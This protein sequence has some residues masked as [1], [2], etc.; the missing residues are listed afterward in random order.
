[1]RKIAAFLFMSL[2]TFFSSQAQ[3]T[4]VTLTGTLQMEV[5][6]A[7]GD[8]DFISNWRQTDNNSEFINFVLYT[9][10]TVDVNRFADV[11]GLLD[12]QEYSNQIAFSL[13]S[14]DLRMG[15]EFAK[16]YANRRVRVTGTL[17][18][19]MAGW[20]NSPNVLFEV[21][22][23]A[24]IDPCLECKRS[25]NFMTEDDPSVNVELVNKCDKD[26]V[27]WIE[28]YGSGGEQ[29]EFVVR[30]HDSAFISGYDNTIRVVKVYSV[31]EP[32]E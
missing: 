27:V 32:G 22:E 14:A 10:N 13:R 17:S 31:R 25:Y 7:S 29:E 30:A 6:S 28:R 16:K 9:D 23:I 5:L 11:D 15:R 26:I 21:E 19:S 24:V 12:P 20:R 1:M 2:L 18:V 3:Q 4:R 8:H